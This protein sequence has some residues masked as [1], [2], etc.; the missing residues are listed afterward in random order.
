MFNFSRYSD[1]TSD[2]VIRVFSFND[3]DGS[4]YLVRGFYLCHLVPN[5]EIKCSFDDLEMYVSLYIEQL[6]EK[7]LSRIDRIASFGYDPFTTRPPQPYEGEDYIRFS[8][9][10]YE[11]NFTYRD[12]AHWLGVSEQAIKQYDKEK[13]NLMLAGLRHLSRHTDVF[14]NGKDLNVVL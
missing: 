12:L 3:L 14:V 11:F 1:L 8:K 2:I 5:Y 10:F 13:R 4:F 6:E 9:M 7:H